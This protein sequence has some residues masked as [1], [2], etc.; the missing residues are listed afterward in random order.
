MEHGAHGVVLETSR[1]GGILPGEDLR[2]DFGVATLTA[3]EYVH[4]RQLGAKC[5]RAHR[6]PAMAGAL[7]SIPATILWI[8]IAVP[9]SQ[10]LARVTG[11][12]HDGVS[13]AR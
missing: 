5:A 3:S 2:H 8:H 1:G 4:Q 9:R 13:S 7:K 6:T 10:R 11:A 12:G